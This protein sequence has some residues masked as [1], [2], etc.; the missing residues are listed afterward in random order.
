MAFDT[1]V[2]NLSFCISTWHTIVYFAP[3]QRN[4]MALLA[5]KVS[6]HSWLAYKGS[7]GTYLK[8]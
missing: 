6:V 2:Q 3:K 4:A 7:W 1:A 5:T 8:L